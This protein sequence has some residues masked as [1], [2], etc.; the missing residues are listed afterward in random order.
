[1]TQD[2]IGEQYHDPV[3]LQD[4]LAGNSS[5]V[6]LKANPA[7]KLDPPLPPQEDVLINKTGSTNG[8]STS[9]GSLLRS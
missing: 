2:L 6:S 1:M 9:V 4:L 7:V 5:E 8:F 3:M